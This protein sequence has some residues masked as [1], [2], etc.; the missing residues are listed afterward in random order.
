MQQTSS[1]R[2]TQKALQN[3]AQTPTYSERGLVV[4]LGRTSC[5]SSLTS[6]RHGSSWRIF[7]QVFFQPQCIKNIFFRSYRS[8]EQTLSLG[9]DRPSQRKCLSINGCLA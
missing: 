5:L 2:P 9:R 4:P 7:L 6:K 3:P 1:L 8:V